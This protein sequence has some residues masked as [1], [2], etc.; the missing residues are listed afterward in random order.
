MKIKQ[1]FVRVQGTEIWVR[2]F[3]VDLDQ[4]KKSGHQ[5]VFVEGFDSI[6][7]SIES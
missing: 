4:L 6:Y 5:L 1:Y 3:K 2:L 7:V